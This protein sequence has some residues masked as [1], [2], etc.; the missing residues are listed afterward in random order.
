MTYSSDFQTH[1]E[2][3]FDDVAK[4]RIWDAKNSARLSP[5]FCSLEIPPNGE[6]NFYS[7]VSN[8][9]GSL[10]S[11]GQSNREYVI[12]SP[13]A[14]EEHVELM[15]MIGSAV[16]ARGQYFT[17]GEVIPIGRPWIYSAVADHLLVSLPYPYGPLLEE[18]DEVTNGLRVS[19]LLPIFKCEADYINEFGVDE[20]EKKFESEALDFLDV[21]RRPV[22]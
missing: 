2:S 7:Y 3:Y 1:V 12:S 17:L 20:L 5:D 14:T 6:L 11:V 18:A 16:K 8:G 22:I 19:W 21:N 13:F 10:L 15:N 9:I 4:K